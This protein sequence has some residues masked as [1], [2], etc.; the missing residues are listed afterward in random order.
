MSLRPFSFDLGA[1]LLAENGFEGSTQMDQIGYHMRID[2]ICCKCRWIVRED[3]LPIPENE[4]ELFLLLRAHARACMALPIMWRRRTTPLL[5]IERGRCGHCDGSKK[6]FCILCRDAGS[7][8]Y[9]SRRCSVC[10]GYKISPS[11]GRA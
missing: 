9:F 6:C 1:K 7:K 3:V 5:A 11:D 2:L 10:K 4:V 8:H